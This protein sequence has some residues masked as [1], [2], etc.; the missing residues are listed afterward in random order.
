MDFCPCKTLR[1]RIGVQWSPVDSTG[2]RCD[3]IAGCLFNKNINK[4]NKRIQAIKA[5]NKYVYITSLA[6]RSFKLRQTT[7]T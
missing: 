6:E 7:T 2:F 4:I 1:E 3:F 5:Y